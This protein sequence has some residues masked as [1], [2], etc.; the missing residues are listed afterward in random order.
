M[1][2]LY[3]LAVSNRDAKRCRSRSNYFKKLKAIC[4]A[5]TKGF[6][7][8]SLNGGNPRNGYMRLKPLLKRWLMGEISCA[9]LRF[10]RL[11][12]YECGFGRGVKAPVEPCAGIRDRKATSQ[13]INSEVYE[14]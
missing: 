1:R 5:V 7:L 13:L 14:A 12:A 10:S 8:N 2:E 3:S 11:P 9:S 4:V 6:L